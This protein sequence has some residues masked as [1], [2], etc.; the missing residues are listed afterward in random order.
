MVL[1]PRQ[2]DITN[3]RINWLF[4]FSVIVFIIGFTA[5]TVRF[6]MYKIHIPIADDL[7]TRIYAGVLDHSY[8]SRLH[9]GFNQSKSMRFCTH[10]SDHDYW[11]D[12]AGKWRYENF[13]CLDLCPQS[14]SRP[15]CFNAHEIIR[16]HSDTEITYVTEID[17]DPHRGMPQSSAFVGWDPKDVTF[18]FFYGVHTTD[19][20]FFQSHSYQTYL[21]ND[22]IT[23]QF[24][25]SQN[26]LTVVQDAQGQERANFPPIEPTPIMTFSIEDIL[27]LSDVH[28]DMVHPQASPNYKPGA[29]FQE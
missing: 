4:I 11:W 26:I 25:S 16:G 5:M 20:S 23:H 3:P 10:P 12:A 24:A 29:I 27:S 21:G 7:W 14:V 2:L 6:D 17:T 18:D 13:T 1:V 15:D 19:Q 9:G 28:F 8:Y 22:I